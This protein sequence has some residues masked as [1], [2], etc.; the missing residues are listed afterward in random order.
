M[1][2][3]FKSFSLTGLIIGLVAAFFAMAALSS[4][5]EI[6]HP[7]LDDFKRFIEGDKSLWPTFEK[8]AEKYPGCAIAAG[9]VLA[10]QKAFDEAEQYFIRALEQKSMLAANALL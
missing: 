2:G 5:Q 1:N 10:N 7:A 8:C 4:E 3:R 9:R 6:A